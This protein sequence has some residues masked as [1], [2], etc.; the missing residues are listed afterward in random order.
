MLHNNLISAIGNTPL[1]KINFD[2]PAQLYAKLEYLNPSGSL[3]DRSAL[4]LIEQAERKGL[5]KPG[6]T[7]IDASSG[8]N[9]ISMAMIGASKGYKVIICVFEK[10]SQEK[11]QT[12]QAYGAEV[13]KCPATRFIEDPLSYH[14]QAAA[15]AKKI[16]NSLFLNQYFNTSNAD[17]HYSMLGPEIWKQ[18]NGK[19][20][21]FFAAA[22]TCGTISGVG[23]FLKEKNPA[24]KVLAVDSINSFRATKGNPLPY[25]LEGVGIDFV[26]PV[27]NTAVIDDYLCVSDEDALGIL[28]PLASKHGFLV[29]LS[30]GAVAAAVNDYAKTMKPED[31]G[32]MVFGDS[33]RAY[34]T[35]GFYD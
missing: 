5:I 14:S 22:G 11:Y 27:L 9:G 30:S 25:K 1:V 19:L 20:T 35:K 15:L 3:K 21:H 13:V 2:S 33:G 29:G 18:T 32:V 6:G 17:A 10:I 23:K 7:L 26:T 12:I 34:L 4:Y 16:P 24:I 31:I 8:N 28:K